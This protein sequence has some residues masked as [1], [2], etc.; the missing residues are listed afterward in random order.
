MRS[1]VRASLGGSSQEGNF[2]VHVFS[3]ES[4]SRLHHFI[5]ASRVECPDAVIK[6][7]LPARCIVPFDVGHHRQ[8]HALKCVHVDE[9]YHDEADTQSNVTCCANVHEHAR[10]FRPTTTGSNGKTTTRTR[11]DRNLCSSTGRVHYRARLHAVWSLRGGAM[12]L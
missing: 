12:R 4:G 10:T 11:A 7:A 1:S 6:S 8:T 3:L 5:P 9:R 2:M